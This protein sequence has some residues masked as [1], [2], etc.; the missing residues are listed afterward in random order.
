[1]GSFVRI[2]TYL[3]ELNIVSI[4]LRL[5]L[6]AVL[7]SVIGM[8]R[9]ATK[10]PAGLRTFA[11]V[12]LGAA[13]AQIVDMKCILMYG[14]GDPV[15]LAQGV[16]SGMGFLGVGTIVVTGKSHIR[17]LTTAA[18]LW[19]TA[20]LGISLGA[21]YLL[22]SLITFILIMFVI[23]IM[24]KYSRRQQRY[25]R[26]LDVQAE[27]SGR[28]GVKALINYARDKGYRIES[29]EKRTEDGYINIYMELDLGRKINHDQII[30]EMSNLPAITFVEE[31]F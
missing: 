12:C 1:M 3:E 20:I 19:T 16:I 7:G 2:F 15:R 23:K 30:E 10:H 22:P 26:E 14:S 27:V 5:I 29:V 4:S 21:G 8:E 24:A 25:T 18:T 31:E 28:E 17:G 9:G 6:A 11:L 13:L